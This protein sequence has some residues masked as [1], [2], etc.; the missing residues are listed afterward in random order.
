MNKCLLTA[1]VLFNTHVQAAATFATDDTAL[2]LYPAQDFALMQGQCKDC[3]IIPQALWYFENEIIAVPKPDKP[4]A[5]FSASKGAQQDI[6]QAELNALPSLVWLGSSHVVDQAKIADDG[7][8]IQLNSGE[9]LGFEITPKIATNL[10]YWDD[11]TLAFFKQRDVRLRG[12]LLDGK[13][14]ARTVWPHDFKLALNAKLQPLQTSESLKSLVQLENGGAKSPYESRLIWGNAS[15]AQGKAVIALMLNGAQGDDDEAHG[16]HFAVATGRVEAD[17][18][19]G[20]WLVNNYYN[21]ASHSEKGII[22][23]ITP[24]DKYLADLNN[25]QNFYRPSYMLVAIL[26][27]DNASLQFQ[28]ATNRIYNHFY[29]NDFV[30]DHSRDNCSGVSID[31]F[32]TLGWN[33]P[34]RGVESQLKATAAYFYVAATEKSLSKGRSIYDYLN[35]EI[36]R[37]FPASAFDAIGEDLLSIVQNADSSRT[38]SDYEKILKKDVE[39]IYFVRIPQIPSSR[40]FGLAPVYRFDQYMS[41]APADRSKWKI[42]PTTPNPFP[43]KLKDGL[44]LTLQ[45][46][47]IVPWPVALVSALLVAGI[48]ALTRKLLK[49]SA[50]NS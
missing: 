27:R 36:T 21:L 4:I 24:M 13:F 28:A 32:R 16:G 15:Q 18:G 39:A 7:K 49:R 50:K 37:L 23:A 5:G 26:K 46:P 30:Y 38:L 29:R 22:A 43:E 1:L 2:G 42:V 31:T 45:K 12:E 40:A 25:G 44:A 19:Y 20:K 34:T 6:L 41:Q 10:S 11:S 14:I 17:G 8:T 3:K 33:I 35:T 47:C 9:T 48:V